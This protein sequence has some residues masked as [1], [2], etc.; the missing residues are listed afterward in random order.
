[1]KG[2]V[3]VDPDKL[4]LPKI[5]NPTWEAV[6]STFSTINLNSCLYIPLCVPN[7]C[8]FLWWNIHC[9]LQ[10]FIESWMWNYWLSKLLE[11]LL[12]LYVTRWAKTR[13]IPHFMRIELRLEIGISMFNCS[14]AKKI[15]A[16]GCLV[17]KLWSGAHCRRGTQ[18]FEKTQCFYVVTVNCNVFVWIKSLLTQIQYLREVPGLPSA[19]HI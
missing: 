6:V 15:E 11:N 14:P 12:V 19:G 18:V 3:R 7:T 13:H 10:L 17:P 2:A 5:Q 9:S 16:I 8:G 1:M 4:G